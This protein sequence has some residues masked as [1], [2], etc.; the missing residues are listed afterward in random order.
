MIT[1][2]PASSKSSILGYV[3]PGNLPLSHAIVRCLYKVRVWTRRAARFDVRPPTDKTDY[4]VMVRRGKF[5]LFPHAERAHR[6]RA[7]WVGRLDNLRLL[8]ASLRRNCDASSAPLICRR[9]DWYPS[10][11]R[12]VGGAVNDIATLHLIKTYCVPSILYGLRWLRVYCRLFG[13][14]R[15]ARAVHVAI[16]HRLQTTLQDTALQRLVW[17]LSLW[18]SDSCSYPAWDCRR[19]YFFLLLS[20]L[21]VFTDF[22]ALHSN[23]NATLQL[24]AFARHSVGWSAGPMTIRHFVWTYFSF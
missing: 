22:T 23:N 13:I 18:L 10:R 5:K 17:P 24:R 4:A 14:M 6:R 9:D 21:E 1:T 15:F 2:R 20:T 8:C 16:A 19:F 7:N 12:G 11:G 3:G